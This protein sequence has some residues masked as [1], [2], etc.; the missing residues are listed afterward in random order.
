M[1]KTVGDQY[2]EAQSNSIEGLTFGDIGPEMS[3]SLVDD[4]NETIQSDPFGGY[5]FYINVVEERDMQMRNAF[6]RRLFLSR[7]R[8]FPEDNTLV[9]YINMRENSVSFCW[10]IPHHSEALNILSNESEYDE[11]YLH[12]IREWKKGNLEPFGFVKIRLNRDQ[13]DGYEDEV[14]N[15]YRKSYLNFCKTSGF[16]KKQLE[17]EVA[18]G[19]F[20][21]PSTHHSYTLIS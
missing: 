12:S 4:L 10:D 8:P 16:T 1:K 20:W 5:S 17:K 3:Q 11:E 18:N 9:F 2:L 7:Y 21:I 19:F 13:E 6:K 14:L 15:N